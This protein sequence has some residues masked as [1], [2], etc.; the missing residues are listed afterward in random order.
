MDRRHFLLNSFRKQPLGV[1]DISQIMSGLSPYS[2]VWDT[3][4]VAQLLRR[5]TFG[6]RKADVNQLLGM[7]MS[8]AVDLLLTPQALPSPPV[9]NYIRPTYPRPRCTYGANMGKCPL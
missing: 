1:T 2:G 5:T 4:Q 3:P 8:A 6:V 9:N 7:S